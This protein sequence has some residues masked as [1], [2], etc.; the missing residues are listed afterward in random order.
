MTV[1]LTEAL[2]FDALVAPQDVGT[3]PVTGG[4]VACAHAGRLVLLAR[5]AP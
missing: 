4:Y 3:A 2:A 1:K 5:P